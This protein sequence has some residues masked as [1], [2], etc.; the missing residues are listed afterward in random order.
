MGNKFNRFEFIFK[1]LKRL[2][3][4]TPKELAD[5]LGISKSAVSQIKKKE[6]FPDE[7]VEKIA[8]KYGK[9]VAWVKQDFGDEKRIN[10]ITKKYND[11]LLKY[12]DL[13]E[14]HIS[15]WT[16]MARVKDL[17]PGQKKIGHR[18]ERQET[19]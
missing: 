17:A 12:S 8:K 3:I 7:W 9:S 14:S 6:E 1:G 13:Q 11:L 5:A 19:A 18:A 16:E 15:L 4:K 10:A 2:N